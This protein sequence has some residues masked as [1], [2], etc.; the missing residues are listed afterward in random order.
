MCPH[1]AQ[2]GVLR[3]ADH[4]SPRTLNDVLMITG[5]PYFRRIS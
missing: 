2:V 5:Q 1:D 4:C 3:R